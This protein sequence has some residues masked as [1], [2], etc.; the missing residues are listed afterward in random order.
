MS[1]TQQGLQPEQLD[2]KNY[3]HQAY[4]GITGELETSV[5][6]ED[7][8]SGPQKLHKC[9]TEMLHKC[10]PVIPASEVKGTAPQ[11]KPAS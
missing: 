7:Q 1:E 5:D 9:H 6:G 2:M 3:R 10:L 4:K 11:S 8:H